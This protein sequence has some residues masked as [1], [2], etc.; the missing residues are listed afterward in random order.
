L[1]RSSGIQE[2]SESESTHSETALGLLTGALDLIQSAVDGEKRRGSG[3]GSSNSAAAANAAAAN[4]AAANAAAGKKKRG[5]AE[6]KAIG[7][8]EELLRGEA[9]TRCVPPSKPLKTR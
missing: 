4:A 7:S 3:Q 5:K 1:K 6:T 2:D 9:S 8:I